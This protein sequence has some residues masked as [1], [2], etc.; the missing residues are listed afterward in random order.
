[1][2]MQEAI[3]ADNPGTTFVVAHVGSY[4]ENLAKVGVW[5][6]KYPNMYIDV[7]ARLDQLGRQPYTARMFL[8]KYQD[9]VIFGT[10]YEAR[11]D[12]VH[13]E[14]FYKTHY[15]F[16]QTYDE[17]FDH[18]FHDSLGQWKIFGVGLDKDILRKI[19]RENARKVFR[20]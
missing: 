13:T 1:M 8:E 12:E 15:R 3:I 9:R 19:Y 16:F 11:F 2:E 10:D 18:P 4:A 17:Y 6:D 7:A 5:L 14:W 20:L